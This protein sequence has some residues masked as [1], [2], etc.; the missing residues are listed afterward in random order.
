MQILR[1]LLA[2]LV[3]GTYVLAAEPP[4]I[5]GLYPSGVQTGSSTRVDLIGK[6]GDLPMQ[7]WS[8]RPELTGQLADDGKSLTLTAAAGAP[9][10]VYWLRLFNASGANRLRPFIVGT[11]PE[12]TEVEPNNAATD[13]QLIDTT[14]T[15]VNGILDRRDKVDTFNVHL[16]AGQTLVA[17]L[18]AHHVRTVVLMTPEEVDEATEQRVDYTPPGQ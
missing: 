14:G 7:L 15:V 4:A 2:S 6:P 13:A 11:L 5:Q 17:S 3:L 1:L 12:V 10:G 9:A 8:N 16:D 18:D